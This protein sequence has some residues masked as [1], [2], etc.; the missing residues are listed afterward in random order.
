VSFR[1]SLTREESCEVEREI[2]D[3]GAGGCFEVPG[4]GDLTTW[5]NVVYC[6]VGRQ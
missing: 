5:G 4:H 2:T 6:E 1:V 3:L